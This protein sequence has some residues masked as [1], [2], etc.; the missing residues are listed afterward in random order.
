MPHN[1]RR[2]QE[3]FQK[4]LALDFSQ[5]LP[6]NITQQLLAYQRQID[7]PEAEEGSVSEFTIVFKLDVTIIGFFKFYKK[8]FSH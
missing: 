5:W 8:Y 4:N 6:T 1:E 7:F 2:G 3:F